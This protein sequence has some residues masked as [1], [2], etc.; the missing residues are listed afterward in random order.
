MPRVSASV[1]AGGAAQQIQ[2][3]AQTHPTVTFL[4]LLVIAEFAALVA[5]RYCFRNVHGG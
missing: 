1:G 2:A 4:V 5:L 3:G